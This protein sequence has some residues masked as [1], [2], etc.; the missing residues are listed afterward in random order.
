V[1]RGRT[2]PVANGM[3]SVVDRMRAWFQGNF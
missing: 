2:A 3:R 1:R